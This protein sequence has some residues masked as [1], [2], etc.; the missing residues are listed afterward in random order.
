MITK[1]DIMN[2]VLN[3]P[4]NTNPAV[5]S[6]MLDSIGSGSSIEMVTLFDDDIVLTYTAGTQYGPPIGQT[7]GT[8]S[9]IPGNGF[10]K[11]T[12]EDFSLFITVTDGSFSMSKLISDSKLSF[13]R[14]FTISSYSSENSYIFRI[15]GDSG[16]DVELEAY[17]Q[18]P[19][20]LKIE[21][22]VL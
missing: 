1:K 17:C 20:H 13:I 16:K 19:H 3:T 18:E 4:T 7:S 21:W 9:A 8:I 10:M 22:F 12:Y 14:S 11:I 6:S 5:L 15:N 2:Y